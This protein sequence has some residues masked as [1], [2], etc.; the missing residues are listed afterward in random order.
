LETQVYIAFFILF[1]LMQ[2]VQTYSRVFFPPSRIFRFWR[3]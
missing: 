3:L 1:D 2:E